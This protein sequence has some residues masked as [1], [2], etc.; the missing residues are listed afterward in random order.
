M[1]FVDNFPYEI[2]RPAQVE[3][4]DTLSRNWSEFDVFVITVPTAGGKTALA[5]SIMDTIRST[6]CIT[7]TNL[8][9][10]Q[11]LDEFPE[12]PT[13]ARLDSY[14]CEKWDRPCPITRAKL[15]NFC[16][17]KRDDCKCPAASD[18]A[19]AKYQKGPGIYNYHT[20]TAHRLHR[21]VLI[22]DE[23]HNLIPFLKDRFSELVWQHDYKYPSNAWSYEQILKWINELPARLKKHKKIAL[24]HEAVKFQVPTHVAQR[25]TEEFNGK[26]TVR[27]RPEQRDCIKLLPVDI[28]QSPKILWP[29]SVKKLVLMSATIGKKDIEQLG[30]GNRRILYIDCKSP[31]PPER[32]LIVPLDTVSVNRHSMESVTDG[33]GRGGAVLTLSNE[34]NKIVEHHTGEK[35]IIH[36]TYQLSGLLRSHLDGPR[37]MFHGRHDKSDVYQQYRDSKPEEGRVLVACG[38]YE[39]IDLPDDMGRFQVISKIPWLSL[40]NPAIKHLAEL[41]P[42]WYVWECLKTTIQAC[43]RICRHPED[44][45][46]T[47][48]TDSS[49]QRLY[50]EGMHMCPEWFLEAINQEWLNE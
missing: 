31:I 21:D 8:L 2:P 19:T 29:T 32:R 23:A 25:T 24:L 17:P 6:S 3:V 18:L 41:D 27:G 7:P 5:K 46:V 22:V 10:S 34:I 44:F 26:G 47:Y 30:L 28:S 42:E 49:F 43:G 15:R 37:F 38:L 33:T 16:S 12:T 14:W 11:F 1:K 45:G 48:I 39:G 4:L 9:V 40:G 36:A 50:R 35:G 13:L 20:Y